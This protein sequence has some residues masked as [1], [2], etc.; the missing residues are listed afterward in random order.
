M[1]GKI[2][3]IQRCCSDDGPGIRTTVFLK[4][5]PLNCAW[6]HN[7]E[8]QALMS[9][10]FY[11]A[12]KCVNCGKCIKICPKGCHTLTNSHVFERKNCIGCGECA[13][14]CQTKAL[15]LC[16]K[17]MSTEEVLK[18]VERDK[19]F[20]DC[21][22]GGVTISG[23]EPLFQP[24]FTAEILKECHK[25]GIHTAIE[26]SGYAKESDLN[27]V[28]DHCDLVLFDIKETNE[29][30]HKFYTGVSLSVILNN[31]EIVNERKIP[32]IIRAP[33]IPS[34]ND[35]KE[36]FLKLKDIQTRLKY[37]QGIQIMPYHNTGEYKYQLL[38]RKYTCCDVIPPDTQTI[39]GWEK[40]L[41]NI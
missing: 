31:L 1:E 36:H 40:L 20:Y 25:S 41:E 37:C 7:P 27:A 26:T 28:L 29:E 17:S 15:E 12:D 10:I 21:S 3:N 33:I 11:D 14:G 38:D 39:R 16:G 4:G 5:C 8:S 22:S 32:F 18:E 19:I 34:I 6:C 35:N 30:K 13:R 24:L 9:E 2:I 23:G